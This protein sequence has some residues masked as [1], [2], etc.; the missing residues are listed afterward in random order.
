M[1]IKMKDAEGKEVEVATMEEY[2]GVLEQLQNATS[3][4]EK[5]KLLDELL[6]DP[7]FQKYL[8]AQDDDTAPP[9]DL[10]V[11][12]P[13]AAEAN[14]PTA[15]VVTQ[16]LQEVLEPLKR[17]IEQL[18]SVYQTDKDSFLIKEAEREVASM[19]SNKQDF[20]FFEEVREEMTK[21]LTS[22]RAVS[23]VDAYRLATYDK[24]KAAGREEVTRKRSRVPL[25]GPSG[26]KGKD[27]SRPTFGAK[28]TLRD[29]L[30]QAADKVGTLTYGEAEEE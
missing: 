29:I 11:T 12:K 24:A 9:E 18:K 26:E 14:K 8:H 27:A 30:E 4:V 19:T 7:G 15:P 13:K 20:P 22:G 6:E 25:L 28:Q 10:T 3:A 21:L 5:A 2:N 17:E 1:P 16:Q 23:L